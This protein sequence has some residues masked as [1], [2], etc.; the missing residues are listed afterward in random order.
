MKKNNL[1][2]IKLDYPEAIDSKR[3]VLMTQRDLIKI[4]QAL[5][6]YRALRL[7]ELQ[8]KSELAKKLKS[9]HN[10]INKLKHLLP[11]VQIPK[12][13]KK[14]EEEVK[15]KR[16]L[17]ELEV[18]KQKPKKEKKIKGKS[19]EKVPKKTPTDDLEKQLMDIQEKLNRLG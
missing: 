7:K 4:A 15:S 10:N 18:K 13:L 11:K 9:A 17:K 8:L 16:E 5:K 2:H 1:I 12:I 3:D 6:N 19:K 14:H